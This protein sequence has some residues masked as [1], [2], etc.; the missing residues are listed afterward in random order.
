[1]MMMIA[2]ELSLAVTNTLMGFIGTRSLELGVVGTIA[3]TIV[4]LLLSLSTA[5]TTIVS[6]ITLL[7]IIVIVVGTSTLIVVASASLVVPVAGIVVVAIRVMNATILLHVAR[8]SAFVAR[9]T[10]KC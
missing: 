3:A 4:I 1:M 2:P 5:S 6:T 8:F 9:S 10:E 7:V